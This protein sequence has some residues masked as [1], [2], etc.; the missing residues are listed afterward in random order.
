MRAIAFFFVV[1][2]LVAGCT[3]KANMEWMRQVLAERPVQIRACEAQK[4]ASAPHRELGPRGDWDEPQ[5]SLAPLNDTSKATPDEVRAIFELHQKYVVPCR[6]MRL[7]Q[8]EFSSE[9]LAVLGSLFA[10]NDA[11]L[12]KVVQGQITWGEAAQAFRSASQNSEAQMAAAP[13]EGAESRRRAS[14]ALSYYL[15]Q[16]EMLARSMKAIDPTYQFRV[17]DCWYVDDL[18]LRCHSYAP[19]HARERLPAWLR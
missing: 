18:R 2:P 12:T 7:I 3:T 6:Q 15:H 10:Q 8:A 17:I 11:T 16:Q 1:A 14:M 19:P 13:R 4:N 9:D 5:P